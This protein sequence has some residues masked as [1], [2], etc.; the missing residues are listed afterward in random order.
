[1]VVFLI[2]AVI[3]PLL[4]A[5]FSDWCPWL[6]ARIVRWAA[7]RLGDP[8]SCK[9][10]EEEWIANLNE[11]PGKLARLAVAFGHLAYMPRMRRSVRRR[12]A[13]S[14]SPTPL[15]PLE[16]DKLRA[17][18]ERE[19]EET[20]SDSRARASFVAWLKD[21]SLTESAIRLQCLSWRE[22]RHHFNQLGL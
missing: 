1:M 2:T 16:I 13:R 12:T 9:R 17:H 15:T 20:Q 4:L 7:R 3:L 11:V 22:L 21:A 6:A 18:F 5:E 19:R 10:Y 14:L 8:A